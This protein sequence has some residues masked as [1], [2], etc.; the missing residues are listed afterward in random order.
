VVAVNNWQTARAF[1]K[2]KWRT[3]SYP[4]RI[5]RDDRRLDTWSL[6]IT[7][8]HA[9]SRIA[10]PLTGDYMA[11]RNGTSNGRERGGLYITTLR[12]I[13]H[14]LESA[15]SVNRFV[16]LDSISRSEEHAWRLKGILSMRVYARRIFIYGFN[17]RSLRGIQFG[18]MLRNY[19]VQTHRITRTHLRRR[20]QRCRT[21]LNLCLEACL[22]G[23]QISFLKKLI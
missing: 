12:A 14:C 5:A 11:R 10:L 18:A 15:Q 1:E 20:P 2:Q 17:R 13:F 8:V 19:V 9:Q 3:Q 7:P 22:R 4:K 21:G 23:E 6:I 16:S